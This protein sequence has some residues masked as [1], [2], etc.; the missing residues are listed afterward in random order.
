MS[1]Y[2]L[3]LLHKR[4][5]HRDSAWNGETLRIKSA[6]WAKGPRQ[7]GKVQLNLSSFISATQGETPLPSPTHSRHEYGRDGTPIRSKDA[8][9]LMALAYQLD[10]DTREPGRQGHLKGSGLRVLHA[11]IFGFWNRY[12]GRCDPSAP[13]IAKKAGVSERTVFRALARLK[14]AGLLWWRRRFQNSNAYR[15]GRPCQTGVESP[16]N[17]FKRGGESL[18]AAFRGAALALNLSPQWLST[19]K[20]A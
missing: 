8:G 7:I 20:L 14:E 18:I 3:D 11:L 5:G 19:Y 12:T 1:H 16:D 17:R 10:A 15:I 2:L 13:S 6:T 9:K 4:A